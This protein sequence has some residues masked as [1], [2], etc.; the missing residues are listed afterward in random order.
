MSERALNATL[1]TSLINEDPFLYAHLIKFER[2]VSTEESKPSKNARDYVYIS[3]ASYDIIFD[4]ESKNVQG[5]ANGAQIYRA[6]RVGKIS[7]IAETTEAKAN[8]L[9]L[10]IN[11]TLLG[12]TSPAAADIAITYAGTS[13]GSTVTLNITGTE[14]EGW[15]ESGFL[16]GDKICIKKAGHAFHNNRA[17]IT[18]FSA[19]GMLL[20]CEALDAGSTTNSIT[21][22]FVVENAADEYE[23]LFYEEY[24]GTAENGA[25]AGYINREVFIYKAHIDPDTGKVIGMNDSTK[26]EGPYLLFKGIIAKAKITEDPSKSSKMSWSLTSHWGDFVRVNGRLTA[27][28]E[29]RALAG[30]GQVDVA[31]LNRFEYGSDLGFMHSERAINMISVYKATETRTRLKSSGWLF[32]KYTQEEYTVQVDREVDLRFNLDAKYL[33]IVYG[34]Q[35]TD[36]IPIFADTLK[37]DSSEI[38][39]VY[40][41]CEGEVGGI[42]DIYIDDQ[43]RI[44]TDKNDNETRGSAASTVEVPCEGRMDRGDTLSSTPAS[45]LGDPFT[46]YIFGGA[47]YQSPSQT[48]LGIPSLNIFRNFRPAQNT[49]DNPINDAGGVT[50]EMKTQMQSPIDAEFIIHSGRKHQRADDLLVSIADKT[51]E[52]SSGVQNQGFKLQEGS[53]NEDNY[54]GPQHR[55]L[56]TVYAVAKY[57]VSEGETEIPS[58]DFVVRGREIEQ[59]NYD[60]SYE[61]HPNP[62]YATGKTATTQEAYFNIGDIVDSYDP[63]NSNAVLGT[64]ITIMDKQVYKNARAEEITKFRFSSD[65]SGGKKVFN[66]VKDGIAA[67]SND[68]LTFATWDFKNS[69]GDL[70]GLI[71]LTVGADTSQHAV[72]SSTGTDGGID[73]F[74]PASTDGQRMRDILTHAAPDGAVLIAFLSAASTPSTTSIEKGLAYF[75]VSDY[76]TSTNKIKN[77]NNNRAALPA[78]GTKLIIVNA[79]RLPLSASSVNGYFK[80]QELRVTRT[81]EDGSLESQSQKIIKYHG[82]SRTVL[83]GDISQ[84]SIDDAEVFVD[85]GTNNFIKAVPGSNEGTVV[86]YA[87]TGATA[88]LTAI[89]ASLDAGNTVVPTDFSIYFPIHGIEPGTRIADNGVDVTNLK[90]TYNRSITANTLANMRHKVIQSAGNEAYQPGV[91]DFIPNTGNSYSIIS[92]GD[93]KVS[94][95]PAIQLLDYLTDTRYGRGLSIDDDINLSSFLNAARKCDTRSDITV[96]TQNNQNP[97]TFVPGDVYEYKVTQNDGTEKVFW[98]GTVLSVQDTAVSGANTSRMITFGNCIGKLVTKHEDWKVYEEGQLI[99]KKHIPA[100]NTVNFRHVTHKIPYFSD[101]SGYNIGVSLSA[102]QHPIGAGLSAFYD[103]IVPLSKVSGS[104]PAQMNTRASTNFSERASADG[105]PF[106]KGYDPVSDTMNDSGYSLYDSDEVKYWRYMGWQSQSQSEVTRHQTNAVI[107]T[108]TPVF[109]NVNG[110]L[111]HFN[112]V[113]RFSDGKYDLAVEQALQDNWASDDIRKINEDD[114]IGAISLDDAGLKGSANSVSVS[115]PDPAIRYDNRSI[116]F[117]N[118]DYL[119]QDRGIPKKKDI[120]TPQIS[121]Y[122]NARMNAEQYLIQSRSNKKINFKVGPKGVLL[123]AGELIKVTYPRFGFNEKVFRIS[124]LSFTPDCLTQIT[125]TEH[126]DKSYKIG[127]KRANALI[128]DARG[129]GDS[130]VPEVVAPEPPTA[131]TAAAGIEKVNLSWT[132]SAFAG[133]NW[134]TEILRSTTNAVPAGILQSFDISKTSHVDTEVDEGITYYY[135][136]RHLR[137]KVTK[138]GKT[139]NVRSVTFP[140]INGRSVTPTVDPSKGH[141]EEAEIYYN[142]TLATAALFAASGSGN[143]LPGGISGFP[144]ITYNF[145]TTPRITGVS[146]GSIVNDQIASTGWFRKPQ[147]QGAGESTFAIKASAATQGI[148]TTD[149]IGPSEWTTSSL[150]ISVPNVPVGDTVSSSGTNL[151]HTFIMSDAGVVSNDY[152]CGFN[153]NRGN[154]AYSYANSGTGLNTFGINILSSTGGVTFGT[155][156]AQADGSILFGQVKIGATGVIT[157]LNA[158]GIIA[159]STVE[160][161]SIVVE[162]IDRGNNSTDIV[163]YTINLRKESRSSRDGVTLTLLMT[164]AQATAF[165][166]TLTNTVAEAVKAAVIA[167]SLTRIC[168]ATNTKRIVANDRITVKNVTGDTTIVSQRVYIGTA[169][170]AADAAGQASDFSSVVSDEFDGSV[171][172]KGTLSADTIAANTTISNQVNVGSI[173]KLGTSLN[174]AN[175]KFY[176]HQKTSFA[177]NAAGI[178]MD[179][180][181]RVN[182]GNADH[183][184]KFDGT[185]FSFNG[186]FSVAGPATKTIVIYKLSSA[187]TASSSTPNHSATVTFSNGAIAF[188]GNFGAG[189]SSIK[190]NGWCT[191]SPAA[192]TANPYVHT[193]IAFVTGEN[194]STVVAAGTWVNGGII[195]GPSGPAGTEASFAAITTL[196]VTTVQMALFA[197]TGAG[198]K[199]AADA[200]FNTQINRDPIIGDAVFLRNSSAG[201]NPAKAVYRNAANNWVLYTA[202]ID[203]SMMVTDTITASHMKADN[204]TARELEISNNSGSGSAG[205]FMNYNSG[206]PKIEI[207]DSSTGNPIRVIIGYLS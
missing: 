144:N 61:Q 187:T 54:W 177:E 152:T 82:G 15:A 67:A 145:E 191:T 146:S 89:K 73:L 188:T 184:M 60:Y 139:L 7:T 88:A 181:G 199:A 103:S 149:I 124:N 154:Q 28:S 99:W 70:A 128:N 198:D 92:R 98:R 90:I 37:K 27:D 159:N 121:N 125:A 87:G 57:K 68:K 116:T 97:N 38:F 22:D 12:A 96:Q 115:I 164:A 62:V 86:T 39:C 31:A 111:K 180:S 41:I 77:I 43:S 49:N 17:V 189:E 142:S 78:A 13:I 3:D 137:S 133:K 196:S 74:I 147:A 160:S 20:S 83:F 176:S 23:S 153:V 117:F 30:N 52:S 123:L 76:D 63:L 162:L 132:N 56:D 157:I 44:C 158:S 136:V 143:L 91:G 183:Y 185:N 108:E 55:L 85:L 156:S 112:G 200:I 166:G 126:D 163:K 80:G 16:I 33:P 105:N 58:V 109:D 8:S 155:A 207:R 201:S 182:I 140:S 138:Q 21:S 179:G 171:I 14:M 47:N 10:E 167:S 4:D 65:P 35:R 94:I 194:S 19:N 66:I 204:I 106:I 203:G 32:K 51:Q 53:E 64:D 114:I 120:K 127:A 101:P 193:K 72:V 130:P 206:S 29:H 2:A 192:T 110:M 190:S 40:A 24:E 11:S 174:D 42:Y 172:V 25:Y 168:T 93:K 141:K 71:E 84:A 26:K 129:T 195:S 205:I 36:S 175:A 151:E 134:K 5:V 113:L 170:G 122:F 173:L 107:R 197:G 102:Q 9:N 1:K 118:S 148:A 46:K 34:V 169:K 131:L 59:Y 202:V 79:A 50:H 161:A 45:H 75:Q 100:T 81:L 6:N 186:Q 135:W 18:A 48:G 150:Y 178:F 95:N 69:S 165:K 119:K 104:G